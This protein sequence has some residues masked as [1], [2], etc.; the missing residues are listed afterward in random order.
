LDVGWSF[1]TATHSQDQLQRAKFVTSNYYREHNLPLSQNVS[2]PP[3]AVNL[4]KLRSDCLPFESQRW[5]TVRDALKGLPD[6]RETNG[7]ANHHFQDGARSYPGH[8]GS[9]MDEPSKALKA[10]DHGVA[11]GENMIRF[12][13][14]T[15]RYFS[16]REAARIQTFPDEFE[17]T[18]SW[19]EN[20][21][22]LGNAVPVLLSKTLASSILDRLQKAQILNSKTHA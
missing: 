16:L 22:Q 17:F 20:M 8:T 10:G 21:R 19:T 18:S 3:S 6:P 4:E 11:G 1:P 14:N 12:P 7:W 2:D 5:Q 15:V 9:P 13:D